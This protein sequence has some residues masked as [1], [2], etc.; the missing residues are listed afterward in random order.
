MVSCGW[1]GCSCN[2][3]YYT[4]DICSKEEENTQECFLCDNKDL[5][6]NCREDIDNF[7]DEFPFDTDDYCICRECI[8]EL[9]NFRIEEELLKKV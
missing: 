4:C 5:C 7:C 2:T 9:V 3:T 8:R 1:S 6:Y